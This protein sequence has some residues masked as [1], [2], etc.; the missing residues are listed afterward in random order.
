MFVTVWWLLKIELKFS[1]IENLEQEN[2]NLKH[3]LHDK[4]IFFDFGLKDHISTSG[5]GV[6][7]FDLERTSSLD[8]PYNSASGVFSVSRSG[9]YFF[10]LYYLPKPTKGLKY[11][12]ISVDEEIGCRAYSNKLIRMG[13]KIL[14]RL[15]WPRKIP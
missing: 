4:S 15:S 13:I 14:V 10:Y 9:L 5:S 8:K 7:K 1:K 11:A 3:Q 12:N 6:L 2:L